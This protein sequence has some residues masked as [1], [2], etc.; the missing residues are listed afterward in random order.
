MLDRARVR[1]RSISAGPGA[2]RALSAAAVLVVWSLFAAGPV[3][4]GTDVAVL[5]AGSLVNLMERAVG[6]EFDRASGDHFRGYAGGS[7][8]LANEITGRLRRADVFLSAS[9]S[10]DARLMGARHGRWV[11]WYL[12]F[13]RSPLVIGYDP[14]SRFARL[15]HSQ[16][17]YE[18][19]QQPGMRI[20]RTDPKL[21]PKGALTVKLMRRAAAYYH[22]PGLARRVLGTPENPAQVLPEQTLIGRLQSGEIDAG[23]FY[24]TETVAAGIPSVALPAAIAPKAQYTIAQVRDAPHPRAAAAFIAFL[25][26]P[27]GRRLM[28]RHGLTVLKPT[29]TGRPNALP[30]SLHRLL[31]HDATR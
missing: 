20:G 24:S 15:W 19:L 12:T 22:R 14:H 13:A 11:R 18:V 29:L 2:R 28:R 26:G 27:Q 30:A 1:N 7:K 17:W 16:P 3:R 10:V 25:L 6:P 4:A 9:P 8:L 21:D 31:K 23:F 5:Y